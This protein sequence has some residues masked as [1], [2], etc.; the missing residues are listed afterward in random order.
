M[1]V[2]FWIFSSV[3]QSLYSYI[4][5]HQQKSFFVRSLWIGIFKPI[6]S[7]PVP[8]TYW[9][10]VILRIFGA[11]LGLGGRFKPGL[12]ISYPWNLHVG[13]Y[14]WL[15]ESV[16]IDS[17]DSVT[18]GNNVCIS[19]GSYLC[20]GNHNYKKPSF[21]L[22]LGAIAIGSESW[23]GAKS[24]VAPSCVI[25]DGA[26]ICIGSVVAGNIPALGVVRGNPAVLVSRRQTV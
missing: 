13:D 7:S 17:L 14:C 6:V 3:I 19:Q 25:G 5:P 8:G 11:R 24:I 12:C 2:V 22:C 1:I 9:R 16:W 26:V 21:D 4:P 15:G 10:K 20:T 23:I 18:I